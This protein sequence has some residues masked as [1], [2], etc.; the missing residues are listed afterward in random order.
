MHAL[1]SSS[2]QVITK[3]YVTEDRCGWLQLM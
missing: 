2:S 3:A 1:I